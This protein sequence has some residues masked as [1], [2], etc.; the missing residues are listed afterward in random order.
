MKRIIFAVFAGYAA[1]AA[2]VM[3]VFAP[4]AIW[5]ELPFRPGT[6]EATLAWSL[7]TLV[8][9]AFGATVAGFVTAWLGRRSAEKAVR[10]LAVLLLVFGLAYAFRNV[11]LHSSNAAASGQPLEPIWYSFALVVLSPTCALLGGR[12]KI[13]RKPDAAPTTRSLAA[14]L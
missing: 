13:A 4:A 2:T 10:A 9:S 6:Q 3:L 11:A 14:T 1:L 12:L 7:Y 8:M 5:P